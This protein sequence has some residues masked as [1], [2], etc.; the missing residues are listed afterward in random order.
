MTDFHGYTTR[1]ISS[2]FVQLECLGTA[3]PR[4]VRLSYKNSGNLLAEVPMASVSTPHGDYRL[5]GGHRLW[6]APEA[7]P[8]SYVPD[9]EGLTATDVPGGLVLEGTT[10]RPTGIR[11]R[12]EVHLD[13]EEARVTLTHTLVNE[14]SWEVELA[15][16]A[17]DVPSR[18]NRS[19]PNPGRRCPH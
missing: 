14:G 4:I 10:E 2:K 18:R 19:F 9:G 17:I 8:R 13:P 5:L 6:H 15:P 7:M 1:H 12:I 16:W 3:G 11:K